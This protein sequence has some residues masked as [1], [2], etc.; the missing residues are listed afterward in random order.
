MSASFLK[1]VTSQHSQNPRLQH[2]LPS[3]AHPRWPASMQKL[4]RA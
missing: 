1:V 2:L 4:L 3:K